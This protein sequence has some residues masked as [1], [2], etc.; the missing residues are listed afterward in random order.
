MA[1]VTFGEKSWDEDSA[2]GGGKSDF[3][4][5]KENGQYVVRIVGK[6]YEYAVHWVDADTGKKRVNCAGK[7]CFLCKGGLKPSIRYLVSVI[8]R[9]KGEG[10]SFKIAEFGPQVYGHIRALYKTPDWGDPRN[11]DIRIN[12][13][14]NRPPA[15]MYF[16]TPMAPKPL[17]ESEKA[18]ASE[19]TSGVKL[20][21]I[22]APLENF[23]IAEKLGP[24]LAAKYGWKESNVSSPSIAAVD[25]YDLNAFDIDRGL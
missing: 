19:F 4:N 24:A 1:K 15:N 17:S 3:L 12:K 18:Q 2:A 20:E 6:P 8:H 13:D 14:A 7:S 5:M 10:D 23:H 25:E 11:Y 21:D 9:V 22:S 16:V